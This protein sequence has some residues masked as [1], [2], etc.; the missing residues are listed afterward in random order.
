MIAF[1]EVR[2]LFQMRR[3][4]DWLPEDRYADH[5]P[6]EE[7]KIYGSNKVR[8]VAQSIWAAVRVTRFVESGVRGSVIDEGGCLGLRTPHW[9]SGGS[10]F[11]G[12]YVTREMSN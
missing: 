10:V 6:G 9:L 3:K 7:D 12:D 8:R 11:C 5:Q 4:R 1:G 2:L